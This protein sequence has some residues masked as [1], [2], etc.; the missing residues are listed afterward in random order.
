MQPN[1]LFVI[2][3]KL[4][5]LPKSEQKIGEAILKDPQK[6]IQMNAT[7]LGKSA[8][9]SPAAIIRFCHSIGLKGFTELKLQ[10]S[11]E[12]KMIEE[13]LYTEILPDEEFEQMKKKLLLTTEH[14]L[15]E[16]SKLLETA[17][18]E[19]VT[20][21]F[22]QSPIIYT[23]GLGASHLVA[24]DIQQKYSRIGKHVM[25]TLDTHSLVASMSTAPKESIFFGISNSGETKEVIQLMKAAQ[26]FGLQTI[27]LTELGE[28]SLK[29]L[30]TISLQT[31]ISGEAPLRSAATSSL[32]TQLY[33][34]DL[35][36]YDFA[37]KNYETI[38]ERLEKSKAGIKLLN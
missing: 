11:A 3:E 20:K 28:N 23:Y 27:S 30:S 21:A 5:S 17:Q 26:K 2:Q 31:G 36:F 1:I 37:T 22:N 10:L 8:N 4:A 15:R 16:T 29:K 12:S 24:L 33:A 13:K 18:V 7:Q 19:E 6:I 14:V 32:L 34:I 38:L 35:L 9:S 25:S